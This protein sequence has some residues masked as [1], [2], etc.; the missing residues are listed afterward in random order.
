MSSSDYPKTIPC[1]IIETIM[2]GYRV[3]TKNWIGDVSRADVVPTATGWGLILRGEKGSE[4]E[5]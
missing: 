4:N 3:E 5:R 1:T 2:I